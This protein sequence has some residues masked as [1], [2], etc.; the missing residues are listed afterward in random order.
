ML[1]S[2]PGALLAHAVVLGAGGTQD[3][4][5]RGVERSGMEV[6]MALILKEAMSTDISSF[7]LSETSHLPVRPYGAPVTRP[8]GSPHKM[9]LHSPSP[10]STSTF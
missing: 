6:G 10:K 3:T 9:T 4:L 2:L 5:T 8:A 1:G 7:R